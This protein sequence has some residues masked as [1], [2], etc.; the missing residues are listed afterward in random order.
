MTRVLRPRDGGDKTWRLRREM[1]RLFGD[2]A[3]VEQNRGYPGMKILQR[4]WCDEMDMPVLLGSSREGR[5]LRFFMLEKVFGE[6]VGTDIQ[7]RMDRFE[8]DMAE[9]DAAL[10]T[11]LEEIC[12]ALMGT[13]H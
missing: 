13:V 2:A 5:V 1:E 12:A 7:K 6:R 4:T 10:L 9:E 3:G 8:D 11:L